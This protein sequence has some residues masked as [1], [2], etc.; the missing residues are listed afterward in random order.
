LSFPMS[1]CTKYGIE[2][3]CCAVGLETQDMF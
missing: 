2:M 1:S 3:L